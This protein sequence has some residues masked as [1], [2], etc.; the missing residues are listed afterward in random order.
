MNNTNDL[1]SCCGADCGAC[2]CYGNMCK[3]CN[4]SCGKVFHAPEGKEC[5]IYFCCRIKNGFHSCGECKKLPCEL[6]LNT[7]DPALS[8]EEFMKT[9]DERV[10]RLKK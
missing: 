5:G 2:P 3:G 10:N 8:D 9:V 7:R 1:I 4:A 6:I